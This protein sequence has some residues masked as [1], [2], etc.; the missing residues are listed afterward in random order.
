MPPQVLLPIIVP[1]LV[2]VP[3]MPQS[4]YMPEFVAEIKPVLRSEV[5]LVSGRGSLMTPCEPWFTSPHSAPPTIYPELKIVVKRE[6]FQSPLLSV[7]VNFPEFITVIPLALGLDKETA[8]EGLSSIV[9]PL[10]VLPNGTLIEA[11]ELSK[12]KFSQFADGLVSGEHVSAYEV[13][14]QTINPT[15]LARINSFSKSFFKTK[16]I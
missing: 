2:R 9:T 7:E 13:V 4:V 6:R 16:L 14:V 1:V 10:I 5:M 3:K 12:T 11:G 8:G 15:M